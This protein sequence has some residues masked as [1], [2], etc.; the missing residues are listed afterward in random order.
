LPPSPSSTTSTPFP[1]SSR[2]PRREAKRPLGALGDDGVEPPCRSADDG[3]CLSDALPEL[4]DV[5]SDPDA[6]GDHAEGE[7]EDEDEERDLSDGLVREEPRE[8]EAR[9][10]D[11]RG[12]QGQ[13]A[14]APDNRLTT[15]IP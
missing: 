3:E 4:G 14:D 11:V 1:G 6:E 13:P 10:V 8:V 5:G 9:Q 2:T 12:L 7:D 15:F